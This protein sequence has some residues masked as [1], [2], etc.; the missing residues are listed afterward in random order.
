MGMPVRRSRTS[1]RQLLRGI[2]VAIAVADEVQLVEEILV[3]GLDA[4]PSAELS[5]VR[6]RCRCTA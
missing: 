3:D 4:A 2:F 1:F 5:A 6:S